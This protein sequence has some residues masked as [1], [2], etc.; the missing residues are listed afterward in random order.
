MSKQDPFAINFAQQKNNAKQR[1]KA[2]RK[3]D[4]ATLNQVKH[5][6][7]QPDQLQSETI[8]LA[9]VQFALAR[10]LGLPSWPRLKAHTEELTRQRHA[11]ENQADA[12]DRDIPTLHVRCGHDL[13][14]CLKICGFQGDFLAMND[15]LCMGPVPADNASFLSIRAHYISDTL[16][17]I[18]DE[19]KPVK[20][21]INDEQHH[22]A[23][24][25]D[26]RYQRVVL[27][28]EH[29][30]YDQF[31][32]LR[33]LQLLA[34]PLFSE[35]KQKII[36]VIEI[37]HFP[38]SARF[39]GL[40]QLPPEA[41]RGLWQQRKPI[42][43]KLISQAST[44]WQALTRPNPVA[45]KELLEHHPLDALPNIKGAI[46]RLLQELP[47]TNTGL[48]Y[49]QQLA[50]SLIAENGGGMLF[51]ELFPKFQQIDPLPTLGDL[52]FFALLLPL[53]KGPAP[54]LILS[55]VKENFFVQTLSL[56]QAGKKCLEGKN[57]IIQAYWVGG[58]KVGEGH[59]WCWD[60]QD[61][62]SLK[63]V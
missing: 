41:I 45:L 27:W 54:L 38:G 22:I 61:L 6:H 4:A 28:V 48:S 15:P 3:G 46:K 8:Q 62:Q 11:I 60:H 19:D 24:L 30:G 33:A 37:N 63:K 18:I 13:Q 53:T 40:G 34:E 39:M 31:M 58:T 57:K 9:D 7:S 43:T 50:L 42:S 32:L 1:L 17:G 36:E 52:M 21:I 49:T 51:R 47:H 56:T 16:M 29:D 23:T 20:D 2:I 59:Q 25:L 5:F 35:Q 12:P 26:A 44:C 55:P 10:E 14:Q